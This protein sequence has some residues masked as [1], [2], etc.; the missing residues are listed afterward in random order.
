[1]RVAGLVLSILM[2]GGCSF[3]VGAVDPNDMSVNPP[4]D[5][6]GIDAPA[7][8]AGIGLDLE[9]FDIAQADLSQPPKVSCAQILAS[10][11]SSVSGLYTI[12]PS[13]TGNP[14]V[15]FCDMSRQGGGWTLVMRSVYDP[16][17]GIQ[18]VTD[19]ATFYGTTLGQPTAGHA[20]RIPGQYWPLLNTTGNHLVIETPRDKG[21][22]DCTPLVYSATGGQWSVGSTIG[23]ASVG[24]GLTETAPIFNGVLQLSTTDSGPSADC[25]NNASIA[26]W[27]LSRCCLT[28]FTYGLGAPHPAV[29]GYV[30]SVADV[31]N[32][33]LSCPSGGAA[34][35]VVGFYLVNTME[36]YVR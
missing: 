2:S 14:I 28:C 16:A 32:A 25:V 21:G 27:T 5:L 26:P 1:M 13:G 34:L 23:T 35:N 22:G 29:S 4:L 31:N 30:D 6:A 9:G 12:D 8:L 10:A 17:E 7:D 20:F 11:P 19:Y 3:E 36:Y 18:L 24:S 33:T 15:T